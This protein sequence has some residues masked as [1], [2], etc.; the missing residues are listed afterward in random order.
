MPKCGGSARRIQAACDHVAVHTNMETGPALRVPRRA[1]IGFALACCSA[2]LYLYFALYWAI[3]TITE[4]YVRPG[5][6]AMSGGPGVILTVIASA[7]VVASLFGAWRGLH[8]WHRDSTAAGNALIFG[9]VIGVPPAALL[10]LVR[11][12]A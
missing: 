3:S 6:I 11:L 8:L 10:L 2:A 12:S 1:W 7:G 9:S 5:D 4:D